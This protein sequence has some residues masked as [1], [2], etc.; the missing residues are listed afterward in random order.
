[1][2]RDAFI[3]KMLAIEHFEVVLMFK[4]VK[5]PPTVKSPSPTLIDM[6]FDRLDT[7]LTNLTR[8][9]PTWHIQKLN[10]TQLTYLITLK[11]NYIFLDT[12]LTYL[13]TLKANYIFLDMELR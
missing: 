1:M 9:W 4:T 8:N 11:A 3:K 13:T 6:Q 12:Q 2:L 7:Q 10:N 5:T